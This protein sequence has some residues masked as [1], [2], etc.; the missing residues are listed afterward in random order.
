MVREPQNTLALII[1]LF[2]PHL[3]LLDLVGLVEHAPNLVVDGFERLYNLPELVADVKLV[4]VE[5]EENEVG[6]LYEV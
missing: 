3:L 4:G 1:I 2:D 6:A 5:E